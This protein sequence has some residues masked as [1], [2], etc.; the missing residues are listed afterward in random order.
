MTPLQARILVF[1]ALVTVDSAI[2]CGLAFV[3][4]RAWA[5]LP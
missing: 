1:L 2:V 4:Y 5:R 3:V